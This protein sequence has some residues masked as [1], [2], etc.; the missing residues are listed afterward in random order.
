MAL[1]AKVIKE[2]EW[3]VLI[4]DGNERVM[5]LD[6][7]TAIKLGIHLMILGQ[8]ALH[9]KAFQMVC[10]DKG[11]PPDTFLDMWTRINQYINILNA[12]QV[13]TEPLDGGDSSSN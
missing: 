2:G 10:M 11:L 1:S 5:L 3:G 4:L 13:D 9:G 7:D 8:D 6:A 12:E